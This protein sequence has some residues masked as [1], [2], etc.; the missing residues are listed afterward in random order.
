MFLSGLSY[1]TLEGG[2][3]NGLPAFTIWTSGEEASDEEIADI[4]I[5]IRKQKK[6][7]VRAVQ[8]RG[9]FTEANDI[10]ILTLMQSL[11]NSKYIIGAVTAG[12]KYFNWMKSCDQVVA[13]T[14]EPEWLGFAVHELWYDMVADGV[15]EVV[16]SEGEVIPRLYLVPG[17]A[18]TPEGIQEFIL[19]AK[20]GWVVHLKPE[21]TLETIVPVGEPA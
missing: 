19:Q 14:S 8:F 3:S 6:G 1:G 17:E 13:I 7:V 5:A 11:K 21:I 20:Y 16:F 2:S 18:V 9:T 4:L 12:R 10:S 15:E